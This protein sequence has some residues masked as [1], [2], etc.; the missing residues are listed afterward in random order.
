MITRKAIALLISRSP[1]SV[2]DWSWLPFQGLDALAKG[3]SRWPEITVVVPAY[4]LPLGWISA[5]KVDL[6][7]QTG[8]QY[9]LREE[10]ASMSRVELVPLVD[11]IV[12]MNQRV[13]ACNQQIVGLG[14][15]CGLLARLVEGFSEAY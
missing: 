13:T 14:S 10:F 15:G 3:G 1:R 6:E 5:R 12:A 11:L 7:L 4:H 9:R 8:G 2:N